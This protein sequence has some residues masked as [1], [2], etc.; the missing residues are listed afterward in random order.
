MS[1]NLRRAREAQRP[2][3]ERIVEFLSV[4]DEEG[5]SLFEIIAGVEGYDEVLASYSVLLVEKAM[6]GV[7]DTH[8]KYRQAIEVLRAAGRIEEVER[9][10]VHYYCSAGRQEE[11]GR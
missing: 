8:E 5:Y 4:H 1:I 11:G 9:E 3:F 10:G 6:T 2:L 7:S